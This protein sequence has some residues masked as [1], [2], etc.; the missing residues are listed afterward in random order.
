MTTQKPN[1]FS[2]FWWDVFDHPLHP[3]RLLSAVRYPFRGERFDNPQ[4]VKVAV[5]KSFSRA[6]FQATSI[7]KLVRRYL[8]GLDLAGQRSGEIIWSL[9]FKISSGV[10]LVV[11]SISEGVGKLTFL[12]TLTWTKRDDFWGLWS[13]VAD[14]YVMEKGHGGKEAPKSSS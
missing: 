3:V 5:H 4:K 8:K 12:L 11:Y 6:T 13:V 10:Y 7:E 2:W 14:V 9:S 1:L